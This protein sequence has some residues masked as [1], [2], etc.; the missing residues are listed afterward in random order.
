MGFDDLDIDEFK[1]IN[2]LSLDG[3]DRSCQIYFHDARP[4][5]G[6]KLSQRRRIVAMKSAF[7]HIGTLMGPQAVIVDPNHEEKWFLDIAREKCK[8]IGMTFIE[9]PT[10]V[11]SSGLN[12]ITRLDHGSLRGVSF[13]SQSLSQKVSNAVL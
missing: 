5:N 8:Q 1:V 10:E 2:G 13:M 3:D 12:W 4:M 6:D 7:R 9:L 11:T